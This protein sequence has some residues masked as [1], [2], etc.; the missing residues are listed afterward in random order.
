MHGHMTRGGHGLPKVS[1][2]PAMPYPSSSYGETIWLF[3]A[4]STLRA[5]GL[6]PSSTPLDTQ[7]R[8]PM[9]I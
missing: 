6:W 8:T 4:W 2:G 7:R 1:P 3:Q 5:G 9:N